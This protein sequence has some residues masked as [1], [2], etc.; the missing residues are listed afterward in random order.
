MNLISNNLTNQPTTHPTKQLTKLLSLYLSFI[1]M[2]GFPCEKALHPR[3]GGDATHAQHFS[4]LASISAMKRS[5]SPSALRDSSALMLR[6]R[7]TT[8]L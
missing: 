5:K 4:K 3:R 8:L 1:F 6:Q 2:F 7:R